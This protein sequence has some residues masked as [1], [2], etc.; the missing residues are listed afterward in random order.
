MSF[1]S[2]NARQSL[3]SPGSTKTRGQSPGGGF[4]ASQYEGSWGAGASGK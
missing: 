4:G 2:S 3:F 1:A